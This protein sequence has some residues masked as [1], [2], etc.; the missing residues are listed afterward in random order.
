MTEKAYSGTKEVFYIQVFDSRG[1]LVNT[2]GVYEKFPS[3]EQIERALVVGTGVYGFD[4]SAK[5]DKRYELRFIADIDADVCTV[6]NGTSLVEVTT[7]EGQKEHGEIIHVQV[8]CAKCSGA[9]A[10]EETNA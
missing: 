2:V 9:D 4:V 8:P 7:R 3:Q 10:E 5:V 6:C 1:N